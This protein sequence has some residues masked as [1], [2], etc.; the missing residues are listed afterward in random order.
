MAFSSN[1]PIPSIPILGLKGFE[2]EFPI[3]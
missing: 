1:I 3:F 2:I